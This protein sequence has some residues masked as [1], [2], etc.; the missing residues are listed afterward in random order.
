MRRF[1]WIAD[2]LG[3]LLALPWRLLRRPRDL[4]PADIRNILLLRCDGIGDLVES[5]PAIRAVRRRFPDAKIELMVGPWAAD[6]AAMIPDVDEVLPYAPWGYRRLR[7]LRRQRSLLV[8]L[9]WSRRLRRRRYD[10]AID[11]RG[12]LLSLLPMAFWKIPRRVGRGTRGGSFALTHQ[13]PAVAPQRQ[14]EVRRTLDVVAWVGGDTGD[15]A[16]A[17][18]PNEA[19]CQRARAA[20]AAAGLDPAKTILFAP[21]AQWK[22]KWWP[23]FGEL[24]KSLIEAGRQVGV[25]GA[26]GEEH[27]HE[28]VR[29]VAPAAVSLIGR[30]DL[31]ALT[32]AFSLARGFVAVDSGPAH[33]AA[34]MG[35]PGVMLF[36]SG[37]PEQF[38]PLA[39]NVRIIHQPCPI[40]PCYQRGDCA[41]KDDW[42]M[43][44]IAPQDVSAALAEVACDPVAPAKH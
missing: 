40:N 21:G 8:D 36:G 35:T 34:G 17:L 30:F 32:A 37:R 19:A 4:D 9:R 28:E 29:A 11:L 24:A 38:G 1:L 16:L 44:K 3:A 12:D 18:T 26:P 15:E 22:W 41:N 7:A 2:R 42:C 43:A 10:L 5:T 23:G 14:H 39:E 13:V 25:L 27:F 20:F 31:T 6:V 33:L